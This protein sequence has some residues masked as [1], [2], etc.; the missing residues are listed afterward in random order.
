VTTPFALNPVTFKGADPFAVWTGGARWWIGN[1][2]NM[3]QLPAPDPDTY[4]APGT[5]GE[6]EHGLAGG[7]S[8]VTFFDSVTRRWSLAWPYLTRRDWQVLNAVHRQLIGTAP[9]VFVPAED[10]NRLTLAQSMCGALNG[11]VEGWKVTAGGTLAYD[12]A[13]VPAVTPGG[14]LAWTGFA[15]GDRLFAADLVGIVVTPTVLAAAPY[16]P[17]EFAAWWCWA[18]VSTGTL[19]VTMRV[20]SMAANGTGV[21]SV[22]QAAMLT[23]TPQLVSVVAGPG[24][25]ASGAYLVPQLVAGAAAS[26]KTLRVSAPMLAFESAP[27]SWDVGVGVPRVVP[28]TGLGRAVGVNRASSASLTLAEAWPS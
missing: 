3:V 20:S 18:S 12:S 19:A 26:G 17:A 9:Y 28:V 25:L 15:S 16:L 10:Y 2:G 7:G 5:R 24:E 23:T 21:T 1:P 13:T 4:T 6:V 11:S 22:D 14:V 8:T 27:R